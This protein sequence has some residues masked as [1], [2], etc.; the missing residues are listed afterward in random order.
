MARR[1]RAFVPGVHGLHHVERLAAPHLADDDAVGSHTQRVAYERPYGDRT[2]PV[3]IR[4]SSLEAHD[5]IPRQAQLGRVFDRD[6]PL[7]SRNLRRRAR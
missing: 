6:H 5:V 2:E 7:T 3:G 4:R 1:Q